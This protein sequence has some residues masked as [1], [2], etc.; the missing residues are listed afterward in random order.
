MCIRDRPSST[1][2]AGMELPASSGTASTSIRAD[3]CRR[4]L[5]GLPPLSCATAR[6]VATRAPCRPQTRTRVLPRRRVRTRPGR[7]RR[8]G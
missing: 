1:R 2:S 3:T 7:R 8:R 4:A 6:G 5:A